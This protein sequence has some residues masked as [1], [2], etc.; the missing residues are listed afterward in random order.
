MA[1]SQTAAGLIPAGWSIAEQYVVEPGGELTLYAKTPGRPEFY[2]TPIGSIVYVISKAGVPAFRTVIAEPGRRTVRDWELYGEPLEG[3][4]R[5]SDIHDVGPDV[6]IGRRPPPVQ[7]AGIGLWW[8]V[9]AAALVWRAAQGKPK[10]KRRNPGRTRWHETLGGVF[11]VGLASDIVANL[12]TQ[13]V[14]KT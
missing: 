8:M 10:R 7:Q 11:L 3:H 9:P 6:I 14:R 4:A 13:G 1:A 5:R 2:T 12:L